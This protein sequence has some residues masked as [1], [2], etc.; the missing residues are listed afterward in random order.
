MNLDDIERALS[1]PLRSAGFKRTLS[2]LL[3]V[4]MQLDAGMFEGRV[5]PSNERSATLAR[6]ASLAERSFMAFAKQDRA[7][8]GTWVTGLAIWQRPADLD[9]ARWREA[10]ATTPVPR[11]LPMPSDDALRAKVVFRGEIVD[12]DGVAVI[13]SRSALR[14]RYA[15]QRF[16]YT[17]PKALLEGMAARELVAWYSVEEGEH[18]VS[19][20]V[21]SDEAAFEKVSGAYATA[22]HAIELREDDALL[23]LAYA[24]LTFGCAAGGEFELESGLVSEL[25][26]DPGFYRVKIVRGGLTEGDDGGA[27]MSF[28]VLLLPSPTAP[29]VESIDV[30]GDEASIPGWRE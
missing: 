21:A 23:V 5:V 11:D 12:D 13:A 10:T 4:W 25:A 30:D 27:G 15:T 26:I 1:Q 28:R 7:A 19:V 9:L 6:V 3:E 29:S 17:F 16:D 18:A 22:E 14:A 24:Q 2:A 20:V 8:A